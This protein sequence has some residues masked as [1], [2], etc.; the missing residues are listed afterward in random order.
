MK[1]LI[2]L[3]ISFLLTACSQFIPV[4]HPPVQQGELI[5]TKMVEQLQTGM[6]TAQV[7]E[8]LGKPLLI[9]VIDTNRLI[10]VYTLKLNFK[11]QKQRTLIVNF[12]NNRMTNFSI[13]TNGG[14]DHFE[15]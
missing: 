9:N 2:L 14:A 13:K 4:Y 6:S 3:I 7:Q 15:E 5:S 11:P 1:R 8:I 12:S 10:Y